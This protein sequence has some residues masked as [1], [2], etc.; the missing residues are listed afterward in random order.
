MNLARLFVKVVGV[1]TLGACA[2]APNEPAVVVLP[3]T[4]RTLEQFQNDDVGCRE[5]AGRRLGGADAYGADGYGTQR[6]YDTAYIQCMYSKGHKVPVSGGYTGAPAGL[7]PPPGV[8]S[9]P[10]AVLPEAPPG[11]APAPTPGAPEPASSPPR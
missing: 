8:Q 11:A 2:T 1:L 9:A 4:G 10:P 7:M 5:Y 6:R 3:G